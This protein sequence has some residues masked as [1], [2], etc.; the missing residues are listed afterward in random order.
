MAM[1]PET[2]MGLRT[3]NNRP[4][5][6]CNRRVVQPSVNNQNHTRVVVRGSDAFTAL[7][8]RLID[9]GQSIWRHRIVRL[10]Y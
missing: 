4:V 10:K 9:L 2:G 5:N 7:G 6:T 1:P 8:I 3:V